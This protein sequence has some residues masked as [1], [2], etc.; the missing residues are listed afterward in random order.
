M[1]NAHSILQRYNNSLSEV[2]YWQGLKD[3]YQTYRELNSIQGVCSNMI[4]LAYYLRDFTWS[5]VTPSLGE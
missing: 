1:A 2:F 4:L 5:I 3:D